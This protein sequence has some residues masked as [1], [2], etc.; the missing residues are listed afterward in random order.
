MII[1]V[2]SRATISWCHAFAPTLEWSFKAKGDT[3]VKSATFLVEDL[4]LI[5]D[6]IVADHPMCYRFQ[7]V[8]GGIREIPV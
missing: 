1:C 8:R 3:R 2:A 5:K 4:P 6:G 7:L